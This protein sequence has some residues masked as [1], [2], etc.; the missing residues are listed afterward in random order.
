MEVVR[1][2]GRGTTTHSLSLPGLELEDSLSLPCSLLVNVRVKIGVGS[3]H[4]GTISNIHDLF[5]NIKV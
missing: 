1:E 2:D 3:H 5:R 4:T